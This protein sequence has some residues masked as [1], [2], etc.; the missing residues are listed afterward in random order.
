MR[1]FYTFNI[2]GKPNDMTEGC[3]YFLYNGQKEKV[4]EITMY[5]SRKGMN[6][7]DMKVFNAALKDSTRYVIDIIP[8]FDPV[9]GKKEKDPERFCKTDTILKKMGK[10]GLIK[11]IRHFVNGTAEQTNMQYYNGQ[12]LDSVVFID[13]HTGKDALISK[14]KNTYSGNQMVKKTIYFYL[15]GQLLEIKE[16]EYSSIGLPDRIGINNLMYKQFAEYRMAY[17]FW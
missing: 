14:E 4:S 1:N 16:I 7:S 13:S 6:V 17:E 12:R 9:I 11:E 2:D 15:D 10:S 5:R 3:V 8:G